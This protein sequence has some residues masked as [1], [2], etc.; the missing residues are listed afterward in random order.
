M[1][2]KRTIAFLCVTA[3]SA[4]LAVVGFFVLPEEVSVNISFRGS[5]EYISK[6]PALIV[7]FVITFLSSS[8]YWKYEKFFLKEVD[9]SD[10][11]M[12]VKYLAFAIIGDLL[13]L[14][15]IVN[16]TIL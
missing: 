5:R 15:V 6:I 10:L 9:P 4:V 11:K 16:N 3:V 12:G 1:V 13:A 2:N 8:L 14:W 7:P